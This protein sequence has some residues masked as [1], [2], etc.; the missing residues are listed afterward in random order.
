MMKQ[1]QVKITFVYLVNLTYN[2]VSYI[3]LCHSQDTCYD[4]GS[5][6][7]NCLLWN[8]GKRSAVHW[9]DINKPS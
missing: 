5:S 2:L 9:L 6:L 8:T 7:K 1:T 3:Q 4:Q